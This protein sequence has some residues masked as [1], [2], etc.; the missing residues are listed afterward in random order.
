MSRVIW[1]KGIEEDGDDDTKERVERIVE[2]INLLYLAQDCDQTQVHLADAVLEDLKELS[3]AIGEWRSNSQDAADDER[4]ER[5]ERAE[6]ISQGRCPSCK[7]K[8]RLPG[9]QGAFGKCPSCKGNGRFGRKEPVTKAEPVGA[10]DN[11]PGLCLRCAK[12]LPP[13]DSFECPSCKDVVCRE[14]LNDIPDDPRCK[15]CTEKRSD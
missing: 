5:A 7:G 15:S 11:L 10:M 12:S 9:M 6:L 3:E 13:I 8:G 4:E 2:C 1:S 14:C